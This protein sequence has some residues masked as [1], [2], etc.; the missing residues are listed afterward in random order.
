MELV[1]VEPR[2]FFVTEE[3]DVLEGSG[4]E[5]AAGHGERGKGKE[6]VDWRVW[7]AVGRASIR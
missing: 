2:A 1:P 6:S 5:E 7:K 3:G 4:A